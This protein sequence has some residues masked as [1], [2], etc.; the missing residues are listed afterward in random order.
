MNSSAVRHSLD[1]AGNVPVNEAKILTPVVDENVSGAADAIT[2]LISLYMFESFSRSLAK[3]K[4]KTN[5]IT[6]SRQ[7]CIISAGKHCVT[8]K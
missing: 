8:L 7:S 2:L 3:T 6:P 4:R 5:G 1:S